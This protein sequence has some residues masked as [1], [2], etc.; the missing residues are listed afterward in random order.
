MHPAELS[1]G[2]QDKSGPHHRQRNHRYSPYR[3]GT[4]T[5]I[6]NLSEKELHNW[7]TLQSAQLIVEKP[8]HHQT[9]TFSQYAIT[10]SA[11]RSR[12]DCNM[13]R[14]WKRSDGLRIPVRPSNNREHL[15]ITAKPT[16]TNWRD[17]NERTERNHKLS[18]G[19][20]RGGNP[21]DPPNNPREPRN[22]NTGRN[23]TD[24]R[25]IANVP[26]L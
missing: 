16:Y 22:I 14:R 20:R 24:K 8:K 9:Y 2:T 10:L 25:G 7:I 26:K 23:P 13:R 19:P 15:Q 3:K 12:Y 4:R 5:A 6:Q 17:E 1:V 21:R 18:V 11:I